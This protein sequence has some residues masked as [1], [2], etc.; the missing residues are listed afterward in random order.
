MNSP[1][2]L[3]LTACLAVCLLCG[4]AFAQTTDAIHDVSL[5]AMHDAPPH[6]SADAT[7][8]TAGLAS[9]GPIDIMAQWSTSVSMPSKKCYHGATK[10]DGTVYIFGG[11]DGTRHF[12]TQCYKFDLGTSMWSGIASLPVQRGLPA[13]QAVNGKVYIIGGYS[14]VNPFAVQKPVLEYDPVTDT[15][16]EKADMPMP[17]FGAGSFV[18]NGRIWVLGG[19]TTA[20]TT[21][22]NAVQIYDPALD[23][24]TFSTSLTPY[25]SWA[26]GVVYAANTVM[27]VGGVRYTAGRGTYGAWA[28]TGSISGDDI[29]W[30]EIED[31]PGLSIMRHSAGSDGS[32]AYFTGGYD[33]GSQNG[34]PP[35][36]GTYAYDPAAGIWILKDKKPTPVYFGS[37]MVFDGTDR[38]YVFGGQHEAGNVTDV[39]ET[40][41]VTAAGGPVAV[42]EKSDLDIWLKN[43]S[44]MTA[45]ITVRNDGSVPLNWSATADAGSAAWLTLSAASG[46]I[47]VGEKADIGLQLSSSESNGTF[48]GTVTITTDD[49]DAASTDIPVTLHVQDEDVDT[50]MNVVLEE[51]TG[52]W[53]GFCP[54]GADT[55]KAM[56]EDYPGRVFGIAYHGGSDH[57]PMKTP[58]TDFWTDIVNLRGW[59]QGAVNRILFDGES[60][61]AIS[62]GAWRARV[63]EVLAT[64][65]SPV[66]ISV[67][68]KSYD[69]S[70]KRVD[71]TIEVFFHR[72]VTSPLRLN[73]AQLQN[74]MNYTQSFY[75][76]SGGSTK[77]FPY[78]HDHVLRQMLPN[79]AGADIAAHAT[80]RSQS[81]ARVDI[82]FT[83]VDSTIETCDLVV[84]VHE[85]DGEHFGE[86]IQAIE[87]PLADFVT[88]LAPLPDGAPLTLHQNYPN[89]FNPSTMVSFDLP[90]RAPVTLVVRD[91]LGRAVATLADDVL[92]AGRHSR[93]FS[94]SGLPSGTYF[95]TLHAGDIV[96]TRS[97]TLMR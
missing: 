39:A 4:S 50:E 19:G 5:S 16:T 78:Y 45:G 14:A 86:I 59:P 52:T 70:S 10:L 38:M 60:Q 72:D 40:F 12:D 21:S 47:P 57:E 35:A 42:F 74:Q 51:G 28:Y 13:V 95:M 6:M 76:Q 15:Y 30:T 8:A 41:D 83:S 77:L 32:K 90:A 94:G 24:W 18:S 68:A 29:T 89:P 97:M 34:G 3:L 56:M 44:D 11:L 75:P 20:F 93:S 73:V 85:S 65:R 88:D 84:F 66:S 62:R 80:M 48:A 25:A 79:D 33:S 26:T 69:A 63:E 71:M 61:Q 87:L 96:R 1:L 17:V 91:A 46:V 58:H 81:T 64:R 31:Y 92:D 22:T 7:A 55:L 82:D 2:P 67:S 43:G 23:Q 54:Y 37:P 53:C 9:G 27:Y 36:G 49:P